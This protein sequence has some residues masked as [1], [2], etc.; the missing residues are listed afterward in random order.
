MQG[1]QDYPD[2]Y[3]PVGQIRGHP[4]K[5]QLGHLEQSQARC[6]NTQ[7]LLEFPD[8][9]TDSDDVD[10]EMSNEINEMPCHKNRFLVTAR[11][12]GAKR[13]QL[14]TLNHV[15]DQAHVQQSDHSVHAKHPSRHT[16]HVEEVQNESFN[17]A[18]HRVARHVELIKEKTVVKHTNH[19]TGTTTI[20]PKSVLADK[21]QVRTIN[22]ITRDRPGETRPP[23]PLSPIEHDPEHHNDNIQ[24]EQ[25]EAEI[26]QLTARLVHKS[27]KRN[28]KSPNEGF[29]HRRSKRLAKQS[30]ATSYFEAPENESEENEAVSRSRT[31]SDSLDI[32][33]T[34]NGISSSSLP[35][36]NMPYRR[37]NEAGYLHATTQ[38]ASIPDISDPESFARYYSKT[39]PPEVRRVLERNSNLWNAGKCLTISCVLAV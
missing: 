33:R 4:N 29:G 5:H 38:S 39:Y 27:T 35:Q 1:H 32:D 37:S 6:Q 21:R 16:V 36:H 15:M 22:R 10:T 17:H 12:V 11:T 7:A 20:S 30:G 3:V 19:P 23:K 2:S 31:I 26:S 34:S 24:I 13:R 9:G 28:L 14:E 25:D 18:V 8:A